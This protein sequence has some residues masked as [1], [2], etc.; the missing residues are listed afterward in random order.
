M[1]TYKCVKVKLS[2]YLTNQAQRHG[3]VWGSGGLDP[4]L[5]TSAIIGGEWLAL[6][7]SVI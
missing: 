1:V 5:L 2:L 3:G 4:R 7:A 6:T